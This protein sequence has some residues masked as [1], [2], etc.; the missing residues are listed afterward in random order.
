MG[1][2]LVSMVGARGGGCWQGQVTRRTP[3]H[4]WCLEMGFQST[5]QAGSV[6]ANAVDPDEA[7]LIT[8][9]WAHRM[10]YMHEGHLEDPKGSIVGKLAEVDPSWVWIVLR[11]ARVSAQD[12]RPL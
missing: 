9:A 11:P 7:M 3:A 2:W 12:G 10:E 6:G 5:F 1:I 4:D 8:G